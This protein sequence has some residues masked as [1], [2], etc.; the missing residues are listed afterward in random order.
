MP[1]MQ[2]QIKCEFNSIVFQLVHCSNMTPLFNRYIPSD[3]VQY[4]IWAFVTSPKFE[5]T[6]F[7]A[8]LLNTVSLA[9][10]FHN[11][12]QV[13]TDFLDVVN[14]IFTAF[15]ACEFVIKLAAYRLKEYFRDPWNTFDFIIVVGS[16]LDIAM[17]NLSVNKNILQT[18]NHQKKLNN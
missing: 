2:N 4:R 7:G 17:T 5:Y 9:M 10:S 11:Q 6:V 14:I 15:F 8:I 18:H 3:P 13:Y 1:S 16:F 12:P